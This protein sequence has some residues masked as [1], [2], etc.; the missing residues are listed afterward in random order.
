MLSATKKKYLFTIYELGNHG[1]S[2][3]SVDIA[4]MLGVK[5]AS[6]SNMLPSLIEKN[7]ISKEDNGIISLT[8]DGAKYASSLYLKY[9]TFTNFFRLN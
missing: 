1:G 6:V 5:K 8:S 4:R 3:R 2:V 9:L 7:M